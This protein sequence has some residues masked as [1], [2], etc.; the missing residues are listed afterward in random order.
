M[1][2]HKYKRKNNHQTSETLPA[3]CPVLCLERLLF[4]RDLFH[5]ALLIAV[6]LANNYTNLPK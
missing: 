4:L 5:F 1:N 2:S 6:L 3:D